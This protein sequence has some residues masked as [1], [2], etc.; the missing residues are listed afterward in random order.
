MCELIDTPSQST[1]GQILDALAELVAEK[2]FETV[3]LRDITNKARVNVAAVN[4][5]FGSKDKLVDCLVARCIQLVNSE[6]IRL[7]DLAESQLADGPLDLDIVLDAFFRPFYSQ[8]SG[9][10]CSLNLYAK[11]M[12]RM[13]SNFHEGLPEEVVPQ[14]QETAARF[15]Q[16]L[17]LALPDVPEES[18]IWGLH[19]SYGAMA[20]TLVYGSVLKQVSHGRSG[21]P[22]DEE[23]LQKMIEFC[24]KGLEGG[25][26]R[27]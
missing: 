10:S 27:A 7:L 5:H 19:F 13:I 1:K 20:H 8:V 25:A 26:Q 9:E 3:S 24:R 6:R 18:I 12:G 2:G 21:T 17:Q 14:F 15:T 22:T 11:L 16:A 4:Y 23:V